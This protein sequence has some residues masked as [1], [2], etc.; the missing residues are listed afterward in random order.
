MDPNN[1]SMLLTD[2]VR[3][4]RSLPSHIIDFLHLKPLTGGSGGSFKGLT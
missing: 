3:Q 1:I 2:L 4:D